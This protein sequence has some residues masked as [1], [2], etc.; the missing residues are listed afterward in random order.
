MTNTNYEIQILQIFDTLVCNILVKLAFDC[1]VP[2]IS[3]FAA[4]TSSKPIGDPR[5]DSIP[6]ALPDRISDS[7]GNCLCS[8]PRVR[9]TFFE[10]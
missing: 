3:I 10:F 5:H 8:Q 1:V 6:G 4:I 7:F 9:K 2:R